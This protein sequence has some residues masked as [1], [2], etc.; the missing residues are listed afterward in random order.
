[1]LSSVYL[2]HDLLSQFSRTR[3]LVDLEIMYLTYFL[4]FSLSLLT[5]C[6]GIWLPNRCIVGYL[7][8]VW[9]TEVGTPAPSS[10][11]V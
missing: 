9:G 7:D 4:V 5:G 6:H 10:K 2:T 3:V 1:M 11:L 8:G